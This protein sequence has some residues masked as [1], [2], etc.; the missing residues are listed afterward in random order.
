MIDEYIISDSSYIGTGSGSFSY[1]DGVMYS[2]S[3][4]IR[5]YQQFIH[6]KGS[7]KTAVR[8]LSIEEQA[9][10]DLA[11]TL[12]GGTLNVAHMEHKYNG[13]F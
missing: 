9:H 7:A 1:I 5:R 13:R 3:F 6:D 12:F 8:S 10:Y 11:M 2:N 4:S